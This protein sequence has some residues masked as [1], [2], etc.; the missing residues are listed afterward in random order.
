[1]SGQMRKFDYNGYYKMLETMPE[2]IMASQL[3]KVK[4][5]LRGIRDYA[6]RKGVAISSLTE[7]E[8]NQFISA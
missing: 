3:P 6:R 5:D 7:A 2:P 8:K 4:L 1:M